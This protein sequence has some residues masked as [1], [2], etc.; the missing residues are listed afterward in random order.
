MTAF[1]QCR[2]LV[3]QV[4]TKK[5]PWALTNTFADTGSSGNEQT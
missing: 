2:G 4:D 5:K 3:C 1:I